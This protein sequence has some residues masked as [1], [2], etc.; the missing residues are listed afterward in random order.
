MSTA[1]R[2]IN[3]IH[4]TKN[5][6]CD[7]GG[8]INNS[9]PQHVAIIPDGNSRWAKAHRLF[10]MDGYKAGL[11]A[12][13]QIVSYANNIGIKYLTVYLMSHENAN[14]RSAKWLQSFFEFALS[15]IQEYLQRADINKYKI[16]TIGDLSRLPDFLRKEFEKLTERTKDNE[17]LVLIVAV[18]YTGQS[19]ILRAVNSVLQARQIT[20]D[21]RPVT[22]KEF[23]QYLDL[24]GIP[25]PDLL[26]RSANEL[27]LSGFLLWHLEYT[28]F[29]FSPELWPDF[30]VERF[31]D[32]LIDYQCRPRNFGKERYETTQT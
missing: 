7:A 10:P 9:I 5:K 1:E 32:I 14:K 13:E 2:K 27:R 26:I 31:C 21:D 17:G 20:G 11:R 12:L 3:L 8:G 18:A 25:P 22:A 19:E 29:A 24:Y 28:E 23:A 15:A 4:E 16:Q 30:S 6:L